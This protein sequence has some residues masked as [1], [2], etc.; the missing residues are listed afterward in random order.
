MSRILI[1]EDEDGIRRV[2]KKILLEE[3]STYEVHEAA[4]GKAG[5]DQ[6]N[7]GVTF[8]QNTTCG[9]NVDHP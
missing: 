6:G 1:I 8:E 7:A 5:I 9:K 2:L 3:D 4:D